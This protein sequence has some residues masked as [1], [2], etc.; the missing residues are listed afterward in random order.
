LVS[1]LLCLVV[2]GFELRVLNLL[3]RPSTIWITSL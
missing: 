3:G 1:W 2:L